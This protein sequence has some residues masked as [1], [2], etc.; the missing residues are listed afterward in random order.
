[1][2][3]IKKILEEKVSE[4]NRRI[5]DEPKFSGIIEGKERSICISVS[6]GEN[7]ISNLKD[8]QL[9]PFVES[10][11][12][13]KDLVVTATSDVLIALIKPGASP[14]HGAGPRAMG[15]GLGPWG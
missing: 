8:M 12:T 9:D 11:D 2:S 10:E 1:M 5:K 14:G 7:Y 6:D 13:S 4:F 15:L 3:N